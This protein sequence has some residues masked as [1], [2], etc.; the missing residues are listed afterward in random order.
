MEKKVGLGILYLFTVGLFGFGWIYDCIKYLI[1]AIK[2]T[3]SDREEFAQIVEEGTEPVT[4][5]RPVE[6]PEIRNLSVK[7][8]LLWILTGL[9]GIFALAF[10]PRFS[11][12]GSSSDGAGFALSS[13]HA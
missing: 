3:N 1:A 5:D 7:I 10:L 4:K 8:I 9:L 12:A 13:G 2:N 6:L 11:G